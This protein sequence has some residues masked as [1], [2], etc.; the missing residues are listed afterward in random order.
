MTRDAILTIGHSNHSLGAFHGLLAKHAV[1]ALVDIRS[2]P[3]S[4]FQ[5]QFN[6]QP[7]DRSMAQ[8]GIAYLHLGDALGGRPSDPACYEEGR[9]RYD[10]V[11]QTEAFRNALRGLLDLAGRHRVALMCAEREPLHCHRTL[12]VGRALEEAGEQVRHILADGGMEDHT[13]AMDRLLIQHGLAPRGDLVSP[14]EEAIATA[15]AR[16]ARRRAYSGGPPMPRG[17]TRQ[18]D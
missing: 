13:D 9:V 17:R 15:I 7:L 3:Y 18:P 1:T 2:S 4:R 11:A 10:R 8:A 6:R 5:P 14:R 12:L 16:E